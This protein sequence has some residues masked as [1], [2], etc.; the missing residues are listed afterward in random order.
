MCTRLLGSLLL[1]T[2][3]R[4]LGFRPERAQELDYRLKDS[5][6][7]KTYKN[8]QKR[9]CL[10]Y[11]VIAT[12]RRFLNSSAIS[13]HRKARSSSEPPSLSSSSS[14]YSLEIQKTFSNRRVLLI[15]IVESF[16][17]LHRS[18]QFR[19]Q[20]LFCCE[21]TFKESENQITSNSSIQSPSRAYFHPAWSPSR[22]RRG[23]YV[24]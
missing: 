9:H 18:C 14:S 8:L 15:V 17:V 5:V 19:Q 23:T 2:T 16:N 11:M 10:V 1:R 7:S 12:F 13:L 3:G 20:Q 22:A 4:G 24:F 6:N 21:S